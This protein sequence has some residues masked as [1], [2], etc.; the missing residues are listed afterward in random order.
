MKMFITTKQN[1]AL[2]YACLAG[3]AQAPCLLL[4]NTRI[5]EPQ[6]HPAN[7]QFQFGQ[8]QVTL[9]GPEF[10]GTDVTAWE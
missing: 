6:P 9:A 7:V 3:L 8:L 10:D 1:T 2:P 4:V 5:R